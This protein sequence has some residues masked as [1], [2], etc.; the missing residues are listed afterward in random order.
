MKLSKRRQNATVYRASAAVAT[1]LA[2]ILISI[3]GKWPDAMPP[4]Q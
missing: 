2:V 4:W 3:G 1:L